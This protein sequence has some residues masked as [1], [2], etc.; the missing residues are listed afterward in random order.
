MS[1]RAVLERTTFRT[2]RLLD[3]ASE[4]ELVAQT[5]H[6]REQWPLV[7]LKELVDNAIDAAEEAGTSP[8]I[9]VVV[10]EAGIEVSDNGPGLT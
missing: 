3:F 9:E 2:S 4:K 10:G 7:I 5:G 6:R 1:A 8:V